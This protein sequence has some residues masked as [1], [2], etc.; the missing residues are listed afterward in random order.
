M[1]GWNVSEIRERTMTV[2]WSKESRSIF[3]RFAVELKDFMGSQT[4]GEKDSL[5]FYG[6]QDINYCLELQK[7]DWK[8]K[9]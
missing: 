6:D 8:R 3:E 9:I 4:S 5:P 7:N 2:I 1:S